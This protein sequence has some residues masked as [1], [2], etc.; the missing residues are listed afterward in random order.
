[1][2]SLLLSRG[3]ILHFKSHTSNDFSIHLIQL[4]KS[5][6][7]RFAPN[8]VDLVPHMVGKILLDLYTGHRSLD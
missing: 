3:A 7:I 1:M 2:I 8:N 4:R 6:L 5:R